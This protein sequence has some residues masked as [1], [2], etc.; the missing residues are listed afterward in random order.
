MGPTLVFSQFQVLLSHL[1][2]FKKHTHT[3]KK[4]EG[5]RDTKGKK[6]G[7]EQERRKE[8]KKM[9]KEKHNKK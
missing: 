8:R 4:K 6:E 2:E 5:R 3:L 7:I 1:W 9:L